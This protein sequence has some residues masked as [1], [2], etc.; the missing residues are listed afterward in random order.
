MYTINIHP[1]TIPAGQDIPAPS[2]SILEDRTARLGLTDDVTV[3]GP[4]DARM[5][6]YLRDMADAALHLAAVI[7]GRL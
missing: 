3:L 6:G 1:V 2:G 4:L 7:E 5:A